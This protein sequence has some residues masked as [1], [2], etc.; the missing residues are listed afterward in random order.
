MSNQ[1]SYAQDKSI[2][3][4]EILEACLTSRVSST[5]EALEHRS[6]MILRATVSFHPSTSHETLAL[7]FVILFCL[8]LP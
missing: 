3:V 5:S 4:T 6:I 1:C 7:C 2:N 8:L